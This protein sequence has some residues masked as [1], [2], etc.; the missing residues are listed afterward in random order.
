MLIMLPGFPQLYPLGVRH[1]ESLRLTFLCSHV[2][3]YA[4]LCC[5]PIPS[6]GICLAILRISIGMLPL[7]KM[8]LL[9]APLLGIPF[10]PSMN[11]IELL[12]DAVL[13]RPGSYDTRPKSS[14]ETL[15][16]LRSI[17]FTAPFSIGI[18]YTLPV[19]LSV[20][21]RDSFCAKPS[22]LPP[23]RFYIKN[24]ACH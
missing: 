23:K 19:L 13:T 16:C 3:L 6:A 22:P 21:V 4:W 24:L 20:T 8:S 1:G 12:H 2:P 5:L 10:S 11:V 7:R 9:Q 18:S 15:I 14:S 17:A